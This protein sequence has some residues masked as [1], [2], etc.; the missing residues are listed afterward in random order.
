MIIGEQDLPDMV[1]EVDQ[2]AGVRPGNLLLLNEA[3]GFPELW[4][5]VPL[6][7]ATRREAGGCDDSADARGRYRT[8]STS[9]AFPGGRRRRFHAG[10]TEPRTGKTYD[11]L[12]RVGRAPGPR[13]ASGPMTTGCCAQWAGE[14]ARARA[15][16]RKRR[17]AEGRAAGRAEGRE[18][19]L[20]EGREA[21]VA[22]G[23]ATDVTRANDVA[24]DVGV[25]EIPHHST[26]RPSSSNRSGRS[27]MKSSSTGG[28]SSANEVHDL[29]AGMMINASPSLRISTSLTPWN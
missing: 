17:W 26:T 9:V 10:L 13:G 16:G 11:V 8:R 7:G 25:Q 22:K 12:E 27:A 18:S 6:A 2:W 21:D 1:I 15:E 20:A 24:A 23:R 5:V 4:V 3:W 14:R 19:G 28:A 29:R